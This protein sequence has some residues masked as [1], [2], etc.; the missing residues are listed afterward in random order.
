MTD[1]FKPVLPVFLA[2]PFVSAQAAVTVTDEGYNLVSQRGSR[3]MDVWKESTDNGAA[4]VTSLCSGQLSQAWFLVP[5]GDETYQIVTPTTGKCLDVGGGS[6]VDGA[7][8]NQ[9][10][11]NTTLNNQRWRI[12]P[13]TTGTVEIVARHSGLCLSAPAAGGQLEQRACTRQ[14]EQAWGLVKQTFTV[15]NVASNLCLEVGGSSGVDGAKV[16]QYACGPFNNK[17]WTLKRRTNDQFSVVNGGSGKCMNAEP[18]AAGAPP[19]LAQ[20]SCNAAQ[21]TQSWRAD[22]QGG[23]QY[24]LASAHNALCAEVP[25]ASKANGVQLTQAACGAA[26]H[27]RWDMRSRNAGPRRDT[28][29]QLATEVAAMLVPGTPLADAFHAAL[30]HGDASGALTGYRNTVLERLR[31]MALGQFPQHSWKAS[32]VIRA[33][34]A[35]LIGARVGTAPD[36][37][38]PFGMRGDPKLAATR[39]NWIV[40]QGKSYLTSYCDFNALVSLPSAY[41]A[42]PHNPDFISKWFQIAGDFARNQANDIAPLLAQKIDFPCR[43]DGN[44][45]SVLGQ[46]MRTGNMIQAMGA[47]AKILGDQQAESA[48]SPAAHPVAWREVLTQRDGPIAQAAYD[49]IALDDFY[50]VVRSLVKD[51]P[52]A[53]LQ[54]YEKA[55]SGRAPDQRRFGFTALL[56]INKLFPEFQAVRDITPRVELAFEKFIDES[57][58]RDGAMLEPS[59]NY[60][61]SAAEGESVLLEL[62]H[63]R[64][65]VWAKPLAERLQDFERFMRSV[66]L[67]TG[68]LPME[69]EYV[70]R[71]AKPVW[72]SPAIWEQWAQQQRNT[73]AEKLYNHPFKGDDIDRVAAGG[74]LDFTSISFPY[75][76][77]AVLRKDW[78]TFSPYLYMSAFRPTV[79]HQM[80]NR[81][82]VQIHAFGR[83]LIVIPGGDSYSAVT[84]GTKE[85]F[86][87]AERTRK[88]NTIMVNGLDQSF[89]MEHWTASAPTPIQAR[90]AFTPHVDFVEGLH[91]NGYG[92]A[93]GTKGVMTDVSHERAVI[94]LRD[95]DLWIMLDHLLVKP[96]AAATT[97]NYAQLW[98]YPPKVFEVPGFQNTEVNPDTSKRTVATSDADGPNLFMYHFGKQGDPSFGYNKQ[99]GELAAP[100]RGWFDTQTKPET[101]YQ[102]AVQVDV[103]WRGTGS[104]QLVTLLAAADTGKSA[105]VTPVETSIDGI[106]SFTATTAGGVK[107]HF[108]TS[109]DAVGLTSGTMSVRAK[110]LLLQR[111]PDGTVRGLVLGAQAVD[112]PLAATPDAIF[113]LEGGKIVVDAPI[114]VPTTFEWSRGTQGWRP[115]YQ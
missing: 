35:Y 45:G 107:L 104:Q 101:R 52:P 48:Q 10:Q 8:V 21:P 37:R 66:T 81:N 105:P 84:P 9:W 11:C 79:G 4:A 73:L 91:R 2:L 14:A 32:S 97:F 23:N 63:A 60:N 39:I 102:P 57:F 50:A 99:F 112:G 71:I 95:L 92:A 77:Y 94:F 46:A 33:D 108:Q 61:L 100:N 1:F 15:K 74:K 42:H 25:G 69:G 55:A 5:V 64:D 93:H 54:A 49:A 80:G 115:V 12:T 38:D 40:P 114:R 59:F 26:T 13:T 28:H 62:G 18:G 34:A 85:A 65:A 58:H 36:P 78:S 87:G 47:F 82:S 19:L 7:T 86:F 30:L 75:S 31:T 103:E 89:G 27:Q 76:G 88:T 98:H 3:C 111:H 22:A 44:S 72:E 53:M 43:W 83:P 106:A 96:E 16:N 67:P 90:S 110:T 113:H 24:R 109:L 56:F 41:H 29:T 70:P 6:R 20:R 51:H 17:E 68:Y